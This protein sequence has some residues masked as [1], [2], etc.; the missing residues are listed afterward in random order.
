VDDGTLHASVVLQPATIRAVELLKEFWGSG[1]TMPARSFAEIAP[2]P[3][4]SAD[5]S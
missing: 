5:R 4:G 1:R 2:Y 3:A